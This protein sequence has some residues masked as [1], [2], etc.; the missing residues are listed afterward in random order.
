MS[1]FDLLFIVLFLASVVTLLTAAVLALRGQRSRA[2]RTLRNFAICFAIYMAVVFAVALATPRRVYAVGEDRCFDDWCIAV[3]AADRAPAPEGILYTVA[4]RLSS[5]AG[6]VS[7][8]E[9]GVRVYLTDDR[10]RRF[11]PIPDPAA[12]PFDV[13][14]APG[15]AVRAKRAFL[16]PPDAHDVGL[17]LSHEGPGWLIIGDD[18]NPLHKHAVVRL[19]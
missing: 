8:R 17:A 19:P 16:V 12:T 13:L 1:I 3:E 4:L 11:D 7:Q 5:H 2:V 6:R 9:K 14:L 18:G 10:G 15:Q